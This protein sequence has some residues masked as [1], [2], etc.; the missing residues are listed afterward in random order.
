MHAVTPEQR[1]SYETNGYF[2]I[3]RFAV[4]STGTR[5]LEHVIELSRRSAADAATE[6]LTE[7]LRGHM[8][9]DWMPINP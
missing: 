7:I 6:D 4:E 9:N 3:E 1:H 2:R 8:I 5:M